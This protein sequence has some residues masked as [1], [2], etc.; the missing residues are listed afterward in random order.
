MVKEV[1]EAASNA[2]SAILAE[3]TGLTANEMIQLRKNARERGIYVKV[4]RNT[5]LRRAFDNTDFS[6]LDEKLVGPLILLLSTEAPGDAARLLK[7]HGKSFDKLKVTAIA[8]SGQ[9]YEPTQ[10]SMIADLPTRSEALSKLLYVMK[11]PVEKFVRTL[12]EPHAKL[13]RAIAAVGDKK[14]QTS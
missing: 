4:V 2:I 13:V 1:A 9:L 8:L 14:Q 5:L 7:E 3:Y 12:A 6:C 10:L 11:A